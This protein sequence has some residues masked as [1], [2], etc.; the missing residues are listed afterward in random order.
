[1]KIKTIAASMALLLAF[2]T[3]GASAQTNQPAA[4]SVSIQQIR[5]ATVKV[6][7]G[8]TTFLVDPMLAKKGAY[9][10][11]EGTYRSEL[12][13]PLIDLPMP[14]AEIVKNIDAVIVTHTHLDHWDE[15]AQQALPK[16]LPLFTQNDADARLIRS[17]G[18]TD[19]RVLQ[20]GTV[21]K[22]VTLSKVGGQH[23]TDEMYAIP[24]LAESLGDAMG[25]V[26]NAP[27]AKT[28]YIV[29]DT[30][31]RDEVT[32]TLNEV[33][34]DVIVLNTGYARMEG[35]DGSIIMGEEDVERAY[36]SAPD[37]RIVAVHMDTVNHAALTRKALGEYVKE[38]GL[39]DRVLIPA[40]GEVM[41]F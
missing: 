17:Q 24:A 19:V 11:F 41:N 21:F 32:Q 15:A 33:K 1:M 38:K 36:R 9:P 5:N 16:N 22:N 23:G 18:F 12:R 6:S 29:G 4:E 3:H 20:N 35:F 2:A 30:I 13:N 7:Y 31:W 28:V 39:G 25:V 8:D 10:G 14:A 26:F 37:S 40:D 27:Q 34:P